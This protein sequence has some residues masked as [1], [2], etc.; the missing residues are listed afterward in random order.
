VCSVSIQTSTGMMASVLLASKNGVSPVGMRFVVR[1][2]QSTPES[3]STH[4]PFTL[5]RLLHRLLR[6]VRLF[7]SAW[8]LP[9]G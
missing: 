6:M 7:I 1:Y 8:P 2:A 3:F 5:P 4:L 9:Y